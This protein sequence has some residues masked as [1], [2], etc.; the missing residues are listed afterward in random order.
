[1]ESKF[2]ARLYNQ[3]TDASALLIRI[4]TPK[5]KLEFVREVFSVHIVLKMFGEHTYFDYSDLNMIAADNLREVVM[6]ADAVLK[7]KKCAQI[8]AQVSGLSEQEVSIALAGS[9]SGNSQIAI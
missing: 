6:K 4:E 5:E 7:A 9:L 1:M 8:I 3:I 2:L